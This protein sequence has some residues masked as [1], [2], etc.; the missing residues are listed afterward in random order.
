MVHDS[1]ERDVIEREEVLRGYATPAER[2]FER[3]PRDFVSHLSEQTSKERVGIVYAPQRVDH[4]PVV[5]TEPRGLL[6]DF[7]V[8]NLFEPAIVLPADRVEESALFG[9]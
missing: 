7:G 1:E 6:D 8:R 4:D 3:H 5:Q 2:L 9:L